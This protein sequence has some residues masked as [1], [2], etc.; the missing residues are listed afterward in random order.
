MSFNCVYRSL[1]KIE[2]NKQTKKHPTKPQQVWGKS[3]VLFIFSLLENLRL[4]WPPSIIWT[5]ITI[6]PLSRT[7]FVYSVLVISASK[8]H[9]YRSIFLSLPWPQLFASGPGDFQDHL[10]HCWGGTSECCQF[11]Y[12]SFVEFWSTVHINCP[13]ATL[14]SIV[15]HEVKI[16]GGICSLLRVGYRMWLVVWSL[17]E[18][19][20]LGACWNLHSPWWGLLCAIPRCSLL[21]NSCFVILL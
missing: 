14:V 3:A 21:L 13:Q 2:K 5:L 7:N 20:S 12:C 15:G 1:K 8:D 18:R 6:L 4:L 19:I 16:A 17:L 11:W 10:S 9:N